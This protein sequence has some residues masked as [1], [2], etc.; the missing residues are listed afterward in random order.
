[1]KIILKIV[2]FFYLTVVVQPSFSQHADCDKMLHLTD[3]IYRANNVSGY[4]NTLELSGNYTKD[5]YSFEKEQ[6]TIWYLINI[7]DSGEFTFDIKTQDKKDDW[8][9]ILYP[10]EKNFCRQIADKK[11]TAIRSNLSR[12]PETGLSATSNHKFVGPGIQPN[13]S[14]SI[15]TNKGTKYVLVVNNPKHSNK[16]HTLILH[17]PS[18]KLVIAKTDSVKKVEPE[19][20]DFKLSIK[21]KI[22]QDYVPSN[23]NITSLGKAPIILEDIINYE[24]ELVKKNY[25]GVIHVSTKGYMLTSIQVN[26][27]KDK[28]TFTQNVFLE[29]I[30]TGKKV[31]LKNLNFFGSKA[32]FLPSAKSPLQA[33]LFFMKINE[34]ITIK[35]EGHVN[36]PR[37]RNSKDY[38]ELS[39]NRAK[40]VKTYLVENGIAKDRISFTGYGNSKMLFPEAKNAEEMSENRRVEIKI[41]SK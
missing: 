33:L 3:T 37:Q 31:N 8:D 23:V 41:I 1:M 18:S 17:Y 22:T 14:K 15:I 32:K 6:N 7:P 26:I 5:K 36:G 4:G 38:I 12:S 13:Y 24:T 20:I 10:H 11:T 28:H 40:A 25:Q 35:I 30:E 29:K 19:L 9:F 21:D 2:T 39:N 34:S 16:S 27:S